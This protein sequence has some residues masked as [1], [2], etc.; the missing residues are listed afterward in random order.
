MGFPNIRTLPFE[1]GRVL[2]SEEIDKVLDYNL[3]NDVL[4][5][6]LFFDK[7][8]KIIDLF[9]FL[10]LRSMYFCILL[11]KMYAEGV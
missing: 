6:K 1:I 11:G 3:Y 2:T 4:G 5:T 8:Q 9:F 10:W 7:C